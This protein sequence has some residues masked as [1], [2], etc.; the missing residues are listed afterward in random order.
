MSIQAFGVLFLL[1]SSA[2]ALWV[3]S[4]FPEIAP[5]NLTRALFRTLIALGVSQVVFPPVWEAALARSPVLV[6]IFSLAVPCLTWVLL[7]AV[8]SIRQLQATLRRPYG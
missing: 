7:S 4:R 5:A 2:V 6:A 8:W 3:D 1:G